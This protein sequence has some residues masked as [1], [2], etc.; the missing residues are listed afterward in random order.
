MTNSN[1][2]VRDATEEDT[3]DLIVLIKEFHKSD[4]V[5][6]VKFDSKHVMK[7]VEYFVDS[8]E[9]LSIVLEVD[10]EIVGCL[11]ASVGPSFL[12]EDLIAN[13][14]LWTISKEYRESGYG[15]NLW[16]AYEDWARSKGAIMMNGSR[17]SNNEYTGSIL[18][19]KGFVQSEVTYIKNLKEVN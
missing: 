4:T 8:E 1:V 3:L 2:L 14:A 16:E 18:E 13:E 11:G 17:L 5:I 7:M 19:S 15:N 9:T 10:G 6:P 12:S